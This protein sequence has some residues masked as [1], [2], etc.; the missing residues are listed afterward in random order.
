MTGGRAGHDGSADAVRRFFSAFGRGDVDGLV[1]A[2]HPEALVAAVRE[3]PRDGGIHGAYRGHAGV[4]EFV[5]ALGAALETEAFEVDGVVGE[6]DVAFA[7][8]RFRHRVRSTGR[9]FESAW[10]L[11]C[12][13]RDGLIQEF[14]FYEDSAAYEAARR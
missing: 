13:V 6:G 14:R 12:R 9:P 4:R 2:F 3:G 1:A 7:S 5:G 10:A 11:R 8:G